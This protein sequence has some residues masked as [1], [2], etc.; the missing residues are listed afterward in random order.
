MATM[1]SA[2]LEIPA[3]YGWMVRQFADALGELVLDVGTGPGVHLPFLGRRRVIALDLSDACLAHIKAL[4]PATETLQGDVADPAVTR[5]LESRG[6][7]TI[8]CLN[9]LEHLPD[10][11]AALAAF[12]R[13]LLARRGRLVLVVPAHPALYGAMD[14]LASHVRRYTRAGLLALLDR[15]GFAV[16]RAR[17]F[18]CLG[19]LAWYANAKLCPVRDLSGPIVNWQIRFFGAVVLPV[20]G[21]ADLL[22]LRVWRVPFGQ[23][24]VVVARPRV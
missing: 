14:R 6:I 21:L 18:N 7:D 8:T 13:I 11:A 24:L 9:V 17:Y 4:F 20:A 1:S 22:F 16:E 19:G 5:P 15:V 3:Y 10:D 2:M 23:S 12:R